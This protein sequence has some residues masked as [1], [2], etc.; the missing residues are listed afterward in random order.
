M[1]ELKKGDL[2]LRIFK[3]CERK[4]YV[5]FKVIDTHP[6]HKIHFN[7]SR[8][9]FSEIIWCSD[10]TYIGRRDDYM[11]LIKSI[12]CIQI[13]I[14]SANEEYIKNLIMIEML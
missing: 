7:D 2:V 13:K 8:Y 1:S 6:L 4:Y 5:I 12:D 3:Y 11:L 14:D 9:V 10:K